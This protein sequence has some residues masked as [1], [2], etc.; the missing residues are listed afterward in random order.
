MEWWVNQNIKEGRW[1]YWRSLLTSINKVVTTASEIY[2]MVDARFDVMQ[3]G[4]LFLRR[5]R[6]V[7]DYIGQIFFFK[8]KVIAS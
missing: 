4:N 5:G 6:L 1:Y 3:N 8:R 2:L 7:K